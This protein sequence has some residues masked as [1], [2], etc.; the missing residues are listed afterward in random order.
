MSRQRTALSGLAMRA[1]CAAFAG[2]G[3]ALA[4]EAAAG[5]D[6]IG[7]HPGMSQAEAVAAM[8][9]HNPKL[10]TYSRPGPSAIVPGVE[11]TDGINARTSNG[12]EDV[13]LSVAMPPNPKTVWGIRRTVNYAPDARP[14]VANI[15]AALRQKYGKE[16]GSLANPLAA[17]QAGVEMMDA[18][19]VFDDAGK[20]VPPQAAR[21]YAESC[22]M[23]QPGQDGLVLSQAA[24]AGFLRPAGFRCD[25]WTFIKAGWQPTP[26]VAGMT[27]GLAMNMSVLLA[28]GKLHG[29]SFAAS[30]AMIQGA[31][32]SQQDAEKRKAAQVKPVL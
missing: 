25:R 19:W 2:V 4:A 16:D 8:Q 1:V 29:E 18:F 10:T 28:D 30:V 23:H 7:V 14:T 12:D 22:G 21:T 6:V 3:A 9:R 26:P 5:P 27:P 11:F 17:Q 15:I 24:R 13:Q 31:A 32:Q 20:R